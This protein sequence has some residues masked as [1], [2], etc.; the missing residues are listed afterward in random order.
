MHR[1]EKRLQ[2][3]PQWEGESEGFGRVCGEREAKGCE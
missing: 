3:K 2:E 1:S